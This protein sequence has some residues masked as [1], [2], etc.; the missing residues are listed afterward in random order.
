MDLD[1]RWIALAR[2]VP[3]ELA[4]EIYLESLCDDFGAPAL[5]ARIALGALL[6]KERLGLTDWETVEA[7]QENPYLQFFIGKE[8]FSHDRPFDASLMVGFRK[9][10]GKEGIVRIS[11][12]IALATTSQVNETP[13]QAQPPRIV[14]S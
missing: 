5:P 3:W 10:F 8:E 2:L 11:E 9:R 7:I 13:S 12:A 14:A 6:I 4:E 1:N